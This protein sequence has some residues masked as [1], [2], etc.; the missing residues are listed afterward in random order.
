MFGCF[1]CMY[2]CAWC[3]KRPEE[4]VSSPR[5]GVTDSCEPS[6][7]SWELNPGPLKEQPVLLNSESH[8]QPPVTF[9]IRI[10]NWRSLGYCGIAEWEGNQRQVDQRAAS[11]TSSE[12]L[13]TAG[14]HSSYSLGA[15]VGAGVERLE[16]CSPGTGVLTVENPGISSVNTMNV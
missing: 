3:L 13:V 10:I 2:V 9:N 14:R 15:C 12:M 4:G 7:G 11:G 5:I 6:C 16:L 1:V 8:L